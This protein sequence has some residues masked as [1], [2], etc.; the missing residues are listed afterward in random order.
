M[1][2]LRPFDVNRA[3][4]F[5]YCFMAAMLWSFFIGEFFATLIKAWIVWMASSKNFKNDQNLEPGFWP[6]LAKG[7]LTS[8]PCLLPTEL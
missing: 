5:L 8:F 1:S 6:R 4:D 7:L 3:E 2:A